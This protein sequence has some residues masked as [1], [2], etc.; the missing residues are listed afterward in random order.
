MTRGYRRPRGRSL[1]LT[2]SPG[3][4]AAMEALALTD[5]TVRYGPKVA[6]D[7]VSLTIPTGS[8]LALIGS[9]GS[10]K[11]TVLNVLAGLAKPANGSIVPSPLPPVAYVLQSAGTSHWL[12]ITAGEVLAMGRYRHRKW[13]SR[14]TSHDK[15]IC[16]EAAERLEV[17][18]LLEQQFGELSGGQK[19]R[20]LVAQAITQQAPVL[21]LDEPITG[22]DIPSQ[23]RILDLIEE[24][25]QRGTTV[26]VTTHNLDE[27]R[28]CD[29][30]A[31][32]AKHLVAVGPP[33]EVLTP[34][35]L[36]QTFGDRVLGRHGG[37]DHDETL[38][39]IDDHGHD[40]PH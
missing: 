38:L 29:R 34:D 2:R 18:D 4:L 3:I 17:N 25:T 11:T 13:L 37:H 32:I 23:N 15:T 19:Q 9:N 1:G 21:L 12:P 16:A 10:G 6:L 35:L 36:R 8:S 20:V 7:N 22:L 31:L 24:E 27:A 28:H 39:V 26:V 40:H 14:L 30:V 33:D 5:V